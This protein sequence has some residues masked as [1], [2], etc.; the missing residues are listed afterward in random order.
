MAV[1]LL[2]TE[3]S[4]SGVCGVSGSAGVGFTGR[5]QGHDRLPRHHGQRCTGHPF[6]ATVL[7]RWSTARWTACGAGGAAID[8]VEPAPV[9]IRQ[10]RG[11]R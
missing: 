8:S 9:P 7:S 10:P 4:S 11:R 5:V 6:A 3:A 1:M 2:V